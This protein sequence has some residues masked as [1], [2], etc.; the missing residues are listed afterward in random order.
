MKRWPN[1]GA[2][3]L[4]L[5]AAMMLSVHCHAAGL[6][7]TADMEQRGPQG[8]VSTGKLFVSG[9]KRRVEVSRGGEGM[10][11]IMDGEKGV[12]LTL[13]PSKKAFTEQQAPAGVPA[14]DPCAGS[15]GAECRKL[16]QEQIAG[17][18][19]DKWEI[20]YRQQGM[21]LTAHQWIDQE[22]HIPLRQEMP[23]G[24]R[25]ELRF[26][27][28][29]QLN[30]REVEKWQ[31]VNSQANKAPVRTFQWYDPQLRQAIKQE[32]PGGYVSEL[33]N[34]HVG[35]VDDA[36]FQVPPGYRKLTVPAQAP[37]PAK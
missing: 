22:R 28:T 13:F 6:S 29:E 26:V 7:Y 24:Q 17:R 2:G 36:L 33:N 32:L 37:Q 4:S 8:V 34:I 23:G 14:A 9:D 20:R 27:G 30:G 25:S 11:S 15:P 12:A 16:G 10:V 21:N 19:V 31:M 18:A 35:S 1:F 5:T 3:P